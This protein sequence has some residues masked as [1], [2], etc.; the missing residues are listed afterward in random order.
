MNLYKV[1]GIFLHANIQL[2]C[3]YKVHPKYTK[4]LIMQMFMREHYIISIYTQIFALVR[5]YDSGIQI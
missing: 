1:L 4:V 2:K 3:T 5:N